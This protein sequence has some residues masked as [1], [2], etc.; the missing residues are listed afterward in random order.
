[1]RAIGYIFGVMVVAMA[2]MF[3]WNIYPSAKIQREAL[4]TDALFSQ[5]SNRLEAHRQTVGQY[6]DSLAA[7]TLTNPA[8]LA[9]I[10][11]IVYR[12]TGSGYALSYTGF[13]GYHKSSVF[14]DERRSH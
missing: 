9:D 13:G 12:R 4:R 2:C 10:Q 11:K 5:I 1:M 7:L 8:D 14:S 6:P 3:A